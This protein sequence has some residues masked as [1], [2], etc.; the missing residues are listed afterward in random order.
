MA[1]PRTLTKEV[2]IHLQGD[3]AFVSTVKYG[4]FYS[5]T[6]EFTVDWEPSRLTIEES[7][8]RQARYLVPPVTLPL[9]K[10]GGA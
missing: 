9:N 7:A 3:C 5:Q 8:V 10:R 1:L 4:C 2:F 6:K